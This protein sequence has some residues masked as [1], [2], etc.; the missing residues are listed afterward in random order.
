M[1]EQELIQDRKRVDI[2]SKHNQNKVEIGSALGRN[3]TDILTIQ[4][5]GKF[6]IESVEMWCKVL[7]SCFF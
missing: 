2:V 7:Y 1:V 5:R 6:E 3:R 4:G